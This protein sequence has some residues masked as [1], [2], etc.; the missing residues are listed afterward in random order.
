MLVLASRS[1]RRAELLTAAGIEFCV[2]AADVDET[3][4]AG[5]APRQYALRM[6]EAKA[7]AVIIGCG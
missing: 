2:R 1:P 7:A 4:R 5:E 6:A 3:P